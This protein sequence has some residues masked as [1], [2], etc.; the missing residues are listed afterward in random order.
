MKKT[1]I[2]FLV[3]FTFFLSS[4]DQQTDVNSLLEITETK[5][6]LFGAILEDHEMMTEFMNRMKSNDHAMMMMKGNDEMMG[7]MMGD[8]TM[9]KMMKDKPAMMNNMMSDM[10]KDG[11]MMEQMMK[12]MNQEYAGAKKILEINTAHPLIKNLSR[13]NM[14]SSTDPLLRSCILQIYEGA[15]LVEGNLTS[16]TEFVSRM[17]E[18]MTTATK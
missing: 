1:I 15:A 7:M 18:I 6:Q 11:K 12:M 17:T 5:D 4:C 10:M 16:P 13:L 2:F 9:M 8:G 3:V 14:G